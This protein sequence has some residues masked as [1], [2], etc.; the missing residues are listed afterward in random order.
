MNTVWTHLERTFTLVRKFI[1]A[2]AEVPVLAYRSPE[3][4]QASLDLEIREQGL[5]EES[6]FALLE[7][8]VME[9]PRTASKSFFN[10][11]FGGRNLPAFSGEVLSALM[12]NSMY[13]FKVAGPQVLIEREVIA[14]MLTKVGY[15]AGAG[16][17]TSGGSIS[18]LISMMI[19]RNE[20]DE[21]IRNQGMR[22]WPMV[23]YT[24]EEGH[25]STRKNAGILGIGR[26]QVQAIPCDGDGKMIPSALEEQIRQDLEAGKIPFFINSTAGTTVL[27]AFD[28]FEEIAVIAR[29]YQLWFH[30][31]GALGGSAV[32]SRKHRHLLKGC[33]QS[34]S[35]TWNAHKM[36]GV[37]LTASAILFNKRP[38]ILR[39]HFSE[40]AEYLFQGEDQFNPGEESIQCG[41]RNDALKIWAAWKYWGDEGYE[42]RIDHVFALA[43]Y[44][45][46]KIKQN[47]QLRLVREPECVNVCFEVKGKSSVE[48]CT[49]LNQRGF[50]K[51]GYGRVDQAKVIR[52]VCIDPAMEHGDIDHFLEKVQE[53]AADI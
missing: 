10:Q 46:E 34:D 15:Q 9:T 39:K 20:K 53:V 8:V 21:Q 23:A 27:G 11:L 32:L 42:Q 28:P 35:Y 36:M 47:P 16:T 48:I 18:N 38:H 25:Y 45:M 49:A 29:K 12:N 7:Q 40:K 51:V 50:I 1:K 4:L 41:R 14:K 24:S 52:L 33:E 6:F 30:I 5:S 31:D 26:D 17:I 19:A 3:E 37:P 13:T 44:A 22:A 43:Q 2:E